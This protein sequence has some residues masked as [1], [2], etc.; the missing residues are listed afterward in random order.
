MPFARP[1]VIALKGGDQIPT[2]GKQDLTQ[3]VRIG[4]HGLTLTWFLTIGGQPIERRS[5]MM[6]PSVT[7]S[8]GE[9]VSTDNDQKAAVVESMDAYEAQVWK[10]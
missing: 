4:L 7:V 10:N 9:R 8:V 5:S 2:V 6:E 3:R 1:F